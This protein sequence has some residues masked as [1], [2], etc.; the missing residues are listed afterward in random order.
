LYWRTAGVS[1][2]VESVV[3]AGWP[4]ASQRQPFDCVGVS[5][6][7]VDQFLAASSSL[8]YFPMFCFLSHQIV[9]LFVG[10]GEGKGC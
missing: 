7:A 9:D 8:Y 2:L 5:W 1:R 10:L 4:L 3:A 6:P